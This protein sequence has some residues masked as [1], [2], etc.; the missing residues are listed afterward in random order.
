MD[1]S[2][3]LIQYGIRSGLKEE[4]DFMKKNKTQATSLDE[5]LERVNKIDDSRP[6]YLTLDLDYFDP[7]YLPG[8]GTP[9]AGGE[10]FHSY[11]K[12]MKLL[13]TKNF[14]GADI[15][16]LAPDVDSSGNSSVFAA[17]VLR[18]TILAIQN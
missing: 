15:V 6:I 4:F 3:Q 14:I 17:K 9:E 8:T 1:E 12:L 7:S 10:T 11:I 5:L 13:K 18:E 2:N 16:E